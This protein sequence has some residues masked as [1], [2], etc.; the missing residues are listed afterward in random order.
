MRIPDGQSTRS[1]PGQAAREEKAKAATATHHG[2]TDPQNWNG[3]P[4]QHGPHHRDHHR[5]HLQAGCRHRDHLLIGCRLQDPLLDGPHSKGGGPQQ[6]RLRRGS[7]CKGRANNLQS[8]RNT[9]LTHSPQTVRVPTPAGVEHPRGQPR[10]HPYRPSTARRESSTAGYASKA[11]PT[12]T[13]NT[14]TAPSTAGAGYATRK[15]TTGRSAR[16]RA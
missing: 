12:R 13:T 16:C 9:A 3:T 15:A 11:A 6:D 8:N 1:G 2:K 4:R 10:H 14:N 5:D 7:K